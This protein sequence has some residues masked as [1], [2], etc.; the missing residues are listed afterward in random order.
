M[1]KVVCVNW[2]RGCDGCSS[3]CKRQVQ[4]VKLEW[5]P[6]ILSRRDPL[7][8]RSVKHFWPEL[9]LAIKRDKAGDSVLLLRL[10]FCNICSSSQSLEC[11]S[12]PHL[13]SS[14]SSCRCQFKD[15]P[16][17]P[18]ALLSWSLLAFIDGLT[19]VSW[20]KIMCI[21]QFRSLSLIPML[22]IDGFQF[23]LNHLSSRNRRFLPTNPSIDSFYFQLHLRFF[24]LLLLLPSYYVVLHIKE[25]STLSLFSC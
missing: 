21:M 16:P 25:S 1:R 15:A 19:S 8:D 18:P 3:Y 13:S 22:N 20:L 23:I 11:Q 17:P 4:N 24:S 2:L 6:K 12:N 14:S 7:S 9:W 5:E 10:H